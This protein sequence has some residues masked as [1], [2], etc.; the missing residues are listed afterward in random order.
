[1]SR[2]PAKHRP[3]RPLAEPVKSYAASQHTPI[4]FERITAVERQ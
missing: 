2:L 3:E 4:K 1:M